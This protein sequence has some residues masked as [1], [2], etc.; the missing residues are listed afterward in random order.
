MSLNMLR[1]KG[2]P[3]P[4]IETAEGLT[5][6][7]ILDK[8]WSFYAKLENSHSEIDDFAE[9]YFLQ[10]L[11]DYP[12]SMCAQHMTDSLIQLIATLYFE[13]RIGE[14]PREKWEWEGYSYEHL[15]LM[16]V[17]SKATIHEAVHR[18][19]TEVKQ[20]LE[21]ASQRQKARS[22]AL[23][24]LIK[25]EK[26]KLKQAKNKQDGVENPNNENGINPNRQIGTE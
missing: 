24:E 14:K 1:S 2:I 22:I 23:E 19:E 7:E 6:K 16:F 8:I 13:D 12:K 20:L 5:A 4:P 9:G 15:A 21:E 25:E 3:L 26:E 10:L 18:K 17:R 11:K